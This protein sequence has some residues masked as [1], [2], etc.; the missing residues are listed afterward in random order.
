MKSDLPA[1]TTKWCFAAVIVVCLAMQWYGHQC[2][3]LF[4]DDSANYVSAS[5]SL[6]ANGNFRSPDGSL[7]TYWPPLFPAT[8]ALFDSPGHAVPWMYSVVTILIGL[9]SIVILNR[10]LESNRFKVLVL[11]LTLTSVQFMMVSVFLWSEMNFLLLVLCV[12]ACALNLKKSNTYVIG[13]LVFAFLMCLQR[14]AGV[15]ILAGVSC[16]IFLDKT[17]KLR[18]RLT[19]SLLV[20]LVG[21]SGLIA[22]NIYLSFVIES[23]FFFY[24]HEFFVHAIENFT[25]ISNMLVRIFIPVSGW[26]SVVIGILLMVAL[27]FHIRNSSPF[28]QLIG[29][30]ILFYLTGLICM[31]RLDIHDIDRFLSVIIFFI[32][33][34]VFES[35]AKESKQFSKTVRILAFPLLLLWTIYPFYRTVNNLRQWNSKSCARIAQNVLES[36]MTQSATGDNF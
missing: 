1:T 8:L 29:L 22:W 21:V 20:F 24:K 17:L 27:I 7:Y 23:G 12:T 28:V 36:T 34:L 33:A 26:I 6:K 35:V 3:L 13:L 31:F 15:F 9:L 19:K 14:N 2:G 11:F 4:T 30:L 18:T 16:W 5:Q 32:Y 10:I 25:T